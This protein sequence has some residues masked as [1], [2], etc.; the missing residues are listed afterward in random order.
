LR[1]LANL[2][3]QRE[4]DPVTQRPAAFRTRIGFHNM[5]RT[6]WLDGRPH[7]DPQAPHTWQGFSTATWEANQLLIRTTHLKES[8]HRRNGIAS[9][10][11]R[12]FTER[13]V[14][15]GDILSVVTIVEDPAFFT[16]PFVR[17]ESWAL[18]PG[19]RV[20]SNPCVYEPEVPSAAGAARGGAQTMYPE[21]RLT[22]GRP[23][24]N[25]AMCTLYCRCM[26][27]GSSCPDG[28]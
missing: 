17:S 24:V 12:T 11:R 22:M 15:H 14:R 26:N 13:W 23:A 8:Y 4:I 1:G 19:Q 5:E 21:F 28:P 25:P 9:S 6:I 18:D 2:R 16:E 7:P 27:E 10:A 3:I 20:T